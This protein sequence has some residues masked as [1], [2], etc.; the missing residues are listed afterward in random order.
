[1][2]GIRRRA[3]T[4]VE[5]LVVIAI[6]GVLI[7]LLLP[8]INAAQEAGRRAAC[9]NKLKQC[10]TASL[11]Y[12]STY[13][14]LPAGSNKGYLIDSNP[15]RGGQCFNQNLA[16]L[17]FMEGKSIYNRFNF[18]V[19][20]NAAPNASMATQVEPDFLCPSWAGPPICYCRC[21]EYQDQAYSMVTCYV[22]NAG[23]VL[24]HTGQY[25]A[26]CPCKDTDTNPVCYCAQTTDHQATRSYSQTPPFCNTDIGIFYSEVPIGCK[27]NR[28]TDGLSKTIMEGE[29]LPDRTLHASLYN[30]NGSTATTN[31][32]MSADM[33]LCPP[34]SGPSSLSN[35]ELHSQ[36]LTQNCDGFKS[37]HPSVCNFVM[38]DASAH[39]F[40]LTID[41][42]VF[43]DLGTKSDGEISTLYSHLAVAPP[44]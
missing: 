41:Y 43:N 26:E 25:P 5:L 10:G 9:V 4:L 15:S 13:G 23:P 31:V 36:N 42:E 12:E 34:V 29:Q 6:I 2:R 8:A 30:L 16:I 19:P 1:M 18:Q 3:F 20:P 37:A 28:I 21:T 32:P 40:P 39:S 22:G 17:P 27:M 44:P 38:C 11:N 14:T 7:A 33:S 24:I 35:A